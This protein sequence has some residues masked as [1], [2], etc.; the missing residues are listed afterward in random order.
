MR[1]K[2]KRGF[3]FSYIIWATVLFLAFITFYILIAGINGNVLIDILPFFGLLIVIKL[4][5]LWVLYGTSYKIDHELLT[6]NFGPLTRKIHISV[7]N[8][9]KIDKAMKYSYRY[10]TSN[11]GIVITFQDKNELFISPANIE[12]FTTEIRK[13]NPNIKVST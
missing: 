6:C 5:L 1:F 10:S 12:S 2:S 8:E 4:L 7:I 9:I 13:V 11:K 3:F